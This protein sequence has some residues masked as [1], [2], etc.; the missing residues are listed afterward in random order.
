[1]RKLAPLL[2]VLLLASAPRGAEVHIAFSGV[3]AHV[4]DG[5]HAPRAVAMRGS[6]AML[7]RPTLHIAEAS[8]AKSDVPLTCDN[9]DCVLEL[10]DTAL[11]FPGGGRPHYVPGGS[12]DTIVPH[13]RAVTNGEML[14]LRDDV[15][16][17]T[18][19]SVISASMELPAGSFSA[20]AFDMKGH[21]EP[22][23]ENRG[24]RPFAQ[25]VFLDGVIPRPEL[26]VR[27]FGDTAWRRITFRDF[28]ELRMVNEPATETMASHHEQ[29]FYELAAQPPAVMPTI[30]VPS[31]RLLDTQSEC[32]NSQWP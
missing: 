22:D 17:P 31:T 2:F 19:A 23:F 26:L 16:D 7:H 5:V 13:L 21:Y 11:R 15:F 28:V 18:P 12:F 30:V 8:I 25:E 32:S 29:L 1:M 3:I 14:A 9:G 4:F 27:R 6:G 20:S 24:E 10:R